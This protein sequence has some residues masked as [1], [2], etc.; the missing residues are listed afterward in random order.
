VRGYIDNQLLV[1]AND[2]TPIPQ[3]ELHGSAL[4]LYKTAAQYDNWRITQP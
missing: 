1:E 3:S 2:P 4:V